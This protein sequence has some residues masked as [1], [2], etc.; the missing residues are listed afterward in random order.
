M[1]RC[2]HYKGFS[3]AQRVPI[4]IFYMRT[5]LYQKRVFWFF[6]FFVLTLYTAFAVF[7]GINGKAY[8][9]TET[10]TSDK[11]LSSYKHFVVVDDDDPVSLKRVRTENLGEELDHFARMCEGLPAS[12]CQMRREEVANRQAV[13]ASLLVDHVIADV[14]WD[15]AD[16]SV[17]RG[18]EVVVRKLALLGDASGSV[19]AVTGEGMCLAFRQADALAEA[20]RAGDLR[21]YA[22]QHK[23]IAAKPRMMA[24]LLRSMEWRGE[25]QRRALA[26]LA[27]Q[28]KFFESLLTIHTGATPRA[29]L[30]ARQLLGFGLDFLTA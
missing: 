4:T 11:D 6:A 2:V 26:S 23:Q 3:S 10:I 28:P 18:S 7:A 30:L 5:Q 22:A 20:L 17:K 8:A 13:R 16:N 15:V 12:L 14:N 29:A 19:D 27:K 24:C 21:Q 25:L 9:Y 1:I